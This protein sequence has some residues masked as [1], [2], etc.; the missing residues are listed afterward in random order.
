MFILLAVVICAP[1]Q[2]KRSSAIDTLVSKLKDQ[3]IKRIFHDEFTD[4]SKW[5]I[6]FQL[7]FQKIKLS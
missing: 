7:S 2:T 3:L 6:Y 5:A 4:R 1:D